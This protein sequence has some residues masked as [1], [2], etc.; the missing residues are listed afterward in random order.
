MYKRPAFSRNT[1]ETLFPRVGVV[2]I[3]EH[4]P[5]ILSRVSFTTDW[6]DKST[7]RDLVNSIRLRS[8]I[9]W[10]IEKPSNWANRDFELNVK[11]C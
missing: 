10:F 9:Y 6:F 11:N 1:N 3:E 5:G 7:D 2:K 4:V 8:G